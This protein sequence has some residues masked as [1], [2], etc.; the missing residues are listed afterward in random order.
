MARPYTLPQSFA[1]KRCLNEESL[2]HGVELGDYEQALTHFRERTADPL[3]SQR[4]K[5]LTLLPFL[6]R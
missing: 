4:W 1:R 5:P 2:G 3:R 6:L